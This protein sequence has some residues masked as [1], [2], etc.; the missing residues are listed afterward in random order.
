MDKLYGSV[1]QKKEINGSVTQKGELNGVLG[2]PSR[3][4][5]DYNLLN[6][7]PSIEDVTLI[8]NKTLADFGDRD[9]SNL[10]IQSIINSVFN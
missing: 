7:K 4:A 9:I 10:E 2:M 8:G 6:N 1:I 3:G 5:S